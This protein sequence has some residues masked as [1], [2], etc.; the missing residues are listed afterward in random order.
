MKDKTRHMTIY[1]TPLP[2]NTQKEYQMATFDVFSG[3]YAQRMIMLT[4]IFYME[5]I[6]KQK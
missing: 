5:S 3:G 6:F 2:R 4:N 1:N